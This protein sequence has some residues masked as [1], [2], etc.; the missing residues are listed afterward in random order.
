MLLHRT[1]PLGEKPPIVVKCEQEDK[2]YNFHKTVFSQI[3]ILRLYLS[4]FVAIKW[5][6][7]Y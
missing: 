4:Y 5:V 1:G 2:E 6:I 3:F 7:F